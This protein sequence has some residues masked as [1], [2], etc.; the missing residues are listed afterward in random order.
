MQGRLGPD[1]PH[2]RSTSANG[3]LNEENTENQSKWTTFEV[4]D[5]FTP[6]ADINPDRNPRN[7]K[8]QLG[9]VFLSTASC[10]IVPWMVSGGHGPSRKLSLWESP[11]P[12]SRLFSH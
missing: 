2:W 10:L 4:P 9:I 6:D 5:P 1:A 3:V 8:N 7:F 12:P 11:L